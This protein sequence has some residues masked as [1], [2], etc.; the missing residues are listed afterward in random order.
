MFEITAL[1]PELWQLVLDEM[2]SADKRACLGAFRFF[3]T[4]ALRSLFSTIRLHFGCWEY[5]HQSQSDFNNEHYNRIDDENAEI[6]CGILS[7]IMRDPSFA[8]L[9]KTMHI[10]IFIPS[11]SSMQRRKYN[12]CSF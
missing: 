5:F 7:R 12:D 2:S 8:A 10:Y 11:V 9:V 6:S 1:P 3:R 4:L